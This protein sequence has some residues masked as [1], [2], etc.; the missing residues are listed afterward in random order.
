MNNYYYF[1]LSA[2]FGETLNGFFMYNKCLLASLFVPFRLLIER[3][4]EINNTS[5]QLTIEING[6]KLS[7]QNYK[8]RGQVTVIW[9]SERSAA[10]G[11]DAP[12]QRIIGMILKFRR[13]HCLASIVSWAQFQEEERIVH[14]IHMRDII[15]FNNQKKY[16]CT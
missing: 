1:F 3:N 9:V 16:I 5:A 6:K 12:S 11:M 4:V 15:S 10:T 13:D 2:N 14:F 8:L 7:V